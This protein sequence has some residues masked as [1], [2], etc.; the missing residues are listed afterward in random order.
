MPN[1][2][3]SRDS[4]FNSDP[5]HVYTYEELERFICEMQAVP[6]DMILKY[7]PERVP[8]SQVFYTLER[9]KEG[10]KIFWDY[11]NRMV[12]WYTYNNQYKNKYQKE[13]QSNVV[14]AGW[15]IAELGLDKIQH[16]A[17]TVFPVQ[18]M[19]AT[20]ANYAGDL[21]V[22]NT[23]NIDMLQTLLPE[24]WRSHLAEGVADSCRHIAVIPFNTD[25]TGFEQFMQK[26]KQIGFHAVARVDETNQTVI[27]DSK[28][29]PTSVPVVDPMKATEEIA[30][31]RETLKKAN[32]QNEELRRKLTQANK[33]NQ[34]LEKKIAALTA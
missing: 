34:A 4:L 17:R 13:Q 21:T 14:R 32:E 18:I 27:I 7:F 15:V 20:S 23:Q 11:N 25:W 9:M 19:F 2:V 3:V 6:Y 22:V 26:I 28:I 1:V 5:T 29:I 12:Y 16:F 33:K 10:G 24:F 31:L 30:T 8:E